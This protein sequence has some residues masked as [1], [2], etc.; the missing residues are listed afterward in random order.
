MT[1]MNRSATLILVL[2][3]LSACG[4]HLKGNRPLPPE[5][6]RVHLDYSGGYSVVDAPVIEQVENELRRRGAQVSRS[7]IESASRLRITHP[8]VDSRTQS[9]SPDGDQLEFEVISAVRYSLEVNGKER[10]PEQTVTARRDYS[11]RTNQLLSKQDED[12][13]V[14]EDMQKELASLV[15]L[16]LEARL[17]ASGQ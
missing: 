9:V 2:V 5:L 4:W 8:I 14:Q 3:L 13:R 16:Q 12:R 6:Q 15:L 17:S 10:I 11:F 7:P 1:P